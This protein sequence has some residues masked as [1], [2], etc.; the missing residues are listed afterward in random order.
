MTQHNYRTSVEFQKL[1]NEVS[2]GFKIADYFNWIYSK[3]NEAYLN[4]LAD[5]TNICYAHKYMVNECVGGGD[6]YNLNLMLLATARIMRKEKID[7]IINAPIN[8]TGHL[9]K[10]R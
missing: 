3:D 4:V 5:Y 10:K 6:N 7:V 1:L 8:T 2:P 9:T